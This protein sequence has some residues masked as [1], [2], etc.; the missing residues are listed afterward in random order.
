M[1]NFRQMAKND[2]R[3]AKE[4][5]QNEKFEEKKQIN[6]VLSRVSVKSKTSGVPLLKGGV[7]D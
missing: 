3:V 5:P 1:Q 2:D 7:A 6:N 4:V